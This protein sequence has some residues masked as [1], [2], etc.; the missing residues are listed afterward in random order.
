MLVLD[1][2]YEPPTQTLVSSLLLTVQ[3]LYMNWACNPFV[4][5]GEGEH[6]PVPASA[7]P[8]VDKLRRDIAVACRSVFPSTG[9]NST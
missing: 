4:P 5:L 1:G 8:G 3:N 7:L 6:D 2:D 9:G